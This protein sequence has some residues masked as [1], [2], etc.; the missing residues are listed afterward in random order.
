[1]IERLYR[2]LRLVRM[3][4]ARVDWA[5]IVLKV[6]L[7]LVCLTTIINMLQGRP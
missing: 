7:L 4:D 6:I 5:V 2:R 3:A 1:M